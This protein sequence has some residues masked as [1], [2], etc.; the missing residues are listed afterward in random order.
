MF[1]NGVSLFTEK[2]DTGVTQSTHYHIG[3]NTGM[4]ENWWNSVAAM[5]GNITIIKCANGNSINLSSYHT[6]LQQKNAASN[7]EKTI[8]SSELLSLQQKI[9]G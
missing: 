5:Y 4:E 2:T 7:T 6:H 3:T 8:N 1:K 9:K